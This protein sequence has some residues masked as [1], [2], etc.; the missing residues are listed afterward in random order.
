[1]NTVVYKY[2]IDA[3]NG[4]VTVPI[5]AKFLHFEVQASEY[6]NGIMSWY[7][8]DPDET[9]TRKDKIVPVLTGDQE[10]L[11]GW[12]ARTTTHIKT[13]EIGGL[14]VHYFALEDVRT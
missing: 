14:M 11:S 5:N 12:N 3:K 10:V 4:D 8:V 9:E 6:G 7:L 1:M 13:L 2:E